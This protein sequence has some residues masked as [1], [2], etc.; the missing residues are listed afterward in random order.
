MKKF[1]I[2]FIWQW[3]NDDW[4]GFN[5]IGVELEYDKSEPSL[6]FKVVIMGVGVDILWVVPWQTKQSKYAQECLKSVGDFFTVGPAM[7]KEWADELGKNQPN[8]FEKE[9]N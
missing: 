2:D 4:I 3:V 7:S 8:D 5:P 1:F 9:E 6:G